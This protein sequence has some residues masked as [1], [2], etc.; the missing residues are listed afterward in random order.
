MTVIAHTR[1]QLIQFIQS[2]TP[3]DYGIARTFFVENP[4]GEAL[5]YTNIEVESGTEGNESIVGDQNGFSIFGKLENK[6]INGTEDSA[7]VDIIFQV[8]T[9]SSLHEFRLS[10]DNYDTKVGDLYY[11][12]IDPFYFSDETKIN[13]VLSYSDNIDPDNTEVF[14]NLSNMPNVINISKSALGIVTTASML[15]EDRSFLTFM[16]NDPNNPT[17]IPANT[18]EANKLNYTF[19]FSGVND[20]TGRPVIYRYN[21]KALNNPDLKKFYKENTSG[22]T[23]S[24]ASD[25][26]NAVYNNYHNKVFELTIEAFNDLTNKSLVD[27]RKFYFKMNYDMKGIKP[28]PI[29]IDNVNP[30]FIDNG[31]NPLYSRPADITYFSNYGKYYK[32]FISSIPSFG[33]NKVYLEYSVK[34]ERSDQWSNWS[35]TN[36]VFTL[37]S[38]A[39]TGG[40]GSRV[41]FITGDEDFNNSTNAYNG[42]TQLKF[43][44]I[45]ENDFGGTSDYSDDSSIL[46]Q[47]FILTQGINDNFLY[48]AIRLP[49]DVSNLSFNVNNNISQIIGGGNGSVV[50]G[51]IGKNN[52]TMLSAS[53]IGDDDD[54]SNE[55]FINDL[56]ESLI[57]SFQS[58]SEDEDFI[59]DTVTEYTLNMDE[60]SD[61]YVFSGYIDKSNINKYLYNSDSIRHT[62]AYGTNIDVYR[63]DIPS[64]YTSIRN[65]NIPIVKNDSIAGLY[66]NFIDPIVKYSDTYEP[67]IPKDSDD[68]DSVDTFNDKVAINIDYTAVDFYPFFFNGNNPTEIIAKYKGELDN[69]IMYINGVETTST[70]TKFSNTKNDKMMKITS[71]TGISSDTDE[72]SFKIYNSKGI[73]V[74]DNQKVLVVRSENIQLS[75]DTFNIGDS[76]ITGVYHVEGT[77]IYNGKLNI[78]GTDNDITIDSNNY[79][80][81][82]ISLPTSITIAEDNDVYIKLTKGTDQYTFKVY[83]NE[84][85]NDLQESTNITVTNDDGDVIEVNDYVS[86][87]MLTYLGLYETDTEINIYRKIDINKLFNSD[88]LMIVNFINTINPPEDL[89]FSVIADDNATLILPI[90]DSITNGDGSIDIII[91]IEKDSSYTYSVTDTDD[92]SKTYT[93]TPLDTNTNDPKLKLSFKDE[94]D[95]NLDINVSNGVDSD[96]VQISVNVVIIPEQVGDIISTVIY[97]DSVSSDTNPL[98]NDIVL[99]P[100]SKIDKDNSMYVMDYNGKK[101]FIMPNYNM[102]IFFDSTI[103]LYRYATSTRNHLHDDVTIS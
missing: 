38:T 55:D 51:S 64:T 79:N 17:V 5:T 92:P 83:V 50:K 16:S 52:I 85:V 4:Y 6:N 44:V 18:S 60:F 28:N 95:Y 62:S 71:S 7:F 66:T 13:T 34:D 97:H 1:E 68:P 25:N 31:I 90:V 99:K 23:L 81:F 43:R 41:R 42:L 61:I 103:K 77:G 76:N 67:S 74:A 56:Q 80:M 100:D 72:I 45:I 33:A 8:T 3:A 30:F 57:E 39:P 15:N 75:I 96:V 48:K 63:V 86:D 89:I 84:L 26:P 40:N 12:D 87:T 91:H 54:L 53:T 49:K 46:Y 19:S 11:L 14:N 35:T 37:Q 27:P 32:D 47:L 10:K 94:G 29:K 65:E 70:V 69:I 93:A 21:I 20:S 58:I 78:N 102:P 73:L 59:S 36:K 82:S 22:Y 88:E 9:Q 2:W 101:K 24:L 98:F